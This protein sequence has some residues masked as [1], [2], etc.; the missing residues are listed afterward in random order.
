MLNVLIKTDSHYKVNRERIR[1]GIED[2]IFRKKIKGD[3]EVSISIVGDR[4]MKKLNS[5]YRSL[6][7]STD[8]LSFPLHDAS[9]DSPFVDPPDGILR[10]GDVVI[11]YPQVLEDAIWDNMLVEDKLD[12]LV[13]HGLNHLLGNHH[14]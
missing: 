2:F 3:L 6:D 10:L 1:T 4:M 5:Q 14:Q 7:E 13:L 8:V 11:S 9:Q 12:E